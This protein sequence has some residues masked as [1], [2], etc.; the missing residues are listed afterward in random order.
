MAGLATWQVMLVIISLAGRRGCRGC[1][2]CS[3][4]LQCF[5][6]LCKRG[7]MLFN[8][9][10]GWVPGAGCPSVQAPGKQVP[11]LAQGQEGK[12]NTCQ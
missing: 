5:A 10:S 7:D 1:V 11:L 9:A 12:A 6:V 4:L 3:G 2:W 8:G